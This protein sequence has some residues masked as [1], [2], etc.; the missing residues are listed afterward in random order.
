MQRARAFVEY[1]Q[2]EA[3]RV[4]SEAGE[5][6]WFAQNVHTEDQSEVAAL[7]RELLSRNAY[8]E[9]PRQALQDADVVLREQGAKEYQDALEQPGSV[10]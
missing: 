2:N 3:Q 9:S 8:E 10:V 1:S 5:Q 4:S 7:M 6:L